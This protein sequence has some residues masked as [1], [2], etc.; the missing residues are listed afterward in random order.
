[1]SGI[2]LIADWYEMLPER[3]VPLRIIVCSDSHGRRA[4][5]EDIVLTHQN[6]DLFLHLGD[7]EREFQELAARY[8]EKKMRGVAGNCDWG[9]TGHTIDSF[10]AQGKKILLTH[11][12]TFGVKAGLNDYLH[13]AR[14]LI[15]DIA[16]YGHTHVAYKG[17]EDGLYVMNPGSVTSPKNGPPSYGMIDITPAGIVLNIVPIDK[18]LWDR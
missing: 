10:I 14:N 7:G 17:Y 9:S 5:L 1:V 16:L 12:H 13:T 3:R 2:V 6:A 11:G 15:A 18:R 8:P 4:V